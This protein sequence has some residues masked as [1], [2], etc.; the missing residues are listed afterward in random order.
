MCNKRN[1][2]E[3]LIV[4][5]LGSGRSSTRR[6]RLDKCMCSLIQSL[7][8]NGYYTYGC[9]C[10]HGKYPMTIVCGNVHRERMFDLISGVDIPR[11]TRFYKKDKQG[12]FYIPESI[13][14]D[15]VRKVR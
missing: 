9:C 15:K 11:N 5:S 1:T 6:I 10:G 12:Y 7:S 8:F 2:T 14:G 4:E 3:G 13:K